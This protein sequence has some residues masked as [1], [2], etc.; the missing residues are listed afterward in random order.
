MTLPSWPEELVS[1][2]RLVDAVWGVVLTFVPRVFLRWRYSR[3]LREDR[4]AAPG[5]GQGVYTVRV[6]CGGG[7]ET[8]DRQGGVNKRVGGRTPVAP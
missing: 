3:Y 2:T 5:G 1:R 4:G 7:R 6:L 8:V